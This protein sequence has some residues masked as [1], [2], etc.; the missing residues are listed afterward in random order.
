MLRRALLAATL[1]APFLPRS[2]RAWPDRPIR[3]IVPFPPGGNTDVM[4]RLV[5]EPLAQR[6]ATP[7]LIENRSGAAS[8]IGTDYVAKSQP[9]GHTILL[10]S[11]ANAINATLYRSLPFDFLRDLAPV[12]RI[13]SI[14]N[15]LTVTPDLPVRS[16][17]ELIAY[18]RAHPGA[19]NYGSPG[20]GTTMHLSGVMFARAADIEAVHVP[21]RGVAQAQND[22]VAG[23]IQFIFDNL[24]V[25]LPLLRDRRTRALAVTAQ[26]RVAQLPGIP[27]MEE[28][29]LPL[30]MQVWGGAFLPAATPAPIRDQLQAAFH[31]VLEAPALASRLADLGSAPDLDRDLGRFRAFMESEQRKWGEVVRLSGATID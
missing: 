20:S 12:A 24:P 6:L 1:A 26:R 8:N 14:P 23:R 17:A 2:A 31:A 5:A 16:V 11:I 22:L 27:T 18:G 25:A 9:D 19:L 21:Y 30:E 3:W 15:V 13:Y 4:A 28:A 10:G 29:G 7:V